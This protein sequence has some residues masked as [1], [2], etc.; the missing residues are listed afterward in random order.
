MSVNLSVNEFRQWLLPPKPTAPEMIPAKAAIVPRCGLVFKQCDVFLFDSKRF[1]SSIENIGNIVKEIVLVI[2]TPFALLRDIYRTLKREIKATDLIVSLPFSVST[3]L[4]NLFI[5]T[6]KAVNT[7]LYTGTRAVGLFF[8]HGGERVVRYIK[9]TFLGSDFYKSGH[10]VLSHSLH[11]RDIVYSSIGATALAIAALFTSILPLQILALP[12]A[13]GSLYGTINNQFTVRNCPEYYTMGHYFDG[14]SLKGHAVKTNDHI[15][16]PIITGCY[17]TTP[18]TTIVGIVLAL[19]GTLPYATAT[20]PLLLAMK[21]IT[22]VL[23]AGL[24]AG[25]CISRSVQNTIEKSIERYAKLAGIA[26][27]EEDRNLSWWDF[28]RKYQET[29]LFKYTFCLKARKELDRLEKYIANNILDTKLP[30][31][32]IAG[33][34]ANNMRNT[35]GYLSA[36]VGTVAI[37]AATVFL[38]IFSL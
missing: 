33:W 26:L 15:I 11:Y 38:R 21:M 30:I 22:V 2:A 1:I 13:M 16:K 20:L 4:V 35:V 17:A 7:V 37:S 14:K 10:T 31:K 18:V 3:A 27:T 12:I 6:I 36:G 28:L 5:S 19:L 29:I 8:W 32:Y 24:V 23:G 9:S 34:Q 25:H